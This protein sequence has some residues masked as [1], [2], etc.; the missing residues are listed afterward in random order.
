V[1][2]NCATVFQ[3]PVRNFVGLS[4]DRFSTRHKTNEHVFGVVVIVLGCSQGVRV[5]VANRKGIC[6]QHDGI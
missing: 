3:L 1:T 6:S 5:A 4:S 2:V